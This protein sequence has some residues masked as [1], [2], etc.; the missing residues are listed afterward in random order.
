MHKLT[1][2]VS[3]TLSGDCLDLVEVADH[4][5]ITHSDWTLVRDCADVY[6]L[7]HA[8][9]IEKTLRLNASSALVWQLCTG[10]GS[11]A[12][13]LR[14]AIHATG[15]ERRRVI[16]DVL[17]AL[18]SFRRHEVIRLAES[19][20]GMEVGRCEEATPSTTS[21][22]ELRPPVDKR[23]RLISH[24]RSGTHYLWELMRSNLGAGTQRESSL[25]DIPKSHKDYDE[26]SVSGLGGKRVIYV[27]RDCR[28]VLVA[29][30]CYFRRGGEGRLGGRRILEGS[31]FHDFI[32][33]RIPED[34]NSAELPEFTRE[35][36][37]DPVGYWV[38]HTQWAGRVFTV[39]YED[40]QLDTI[41]SLVR[42][43]REFGM[44][45]DSR[46]FT[47]LSGLVGHYPRRGVVGDW[48]EWFDSSDLDYVESIAGE[49]MLE[50]GYELNSRE[51][52]SRV[53]APDSDINR[54][55]FINLSRR[56]DREQATRD[57]LLRAGVNGFSR[58]DAIDGLEH[59]SV[60]TMLDRV[61]MRLSR[62]FLDN[63]PDFDPFSP[64][65]RAKAGCWLSHYLVIASIR[66]P[67]GWT[68]VL[69]DDIRV[70][71]SWGVLSNRLWHTLAAFPDADVVVV[72]QR[73]GMAVD[74]SRRGADGYLV[75]NRSAEKLRKLLRTDCE[76]IES[77]AL[78]DRLVQL[79][80][81]GRVTI[82]ELSGGEWL[83]CMEVGRG[84]DSDIEN[85]SE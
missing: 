14:E 34:V 28:D 6:Y 80:K 16:Q 42:I 75:R 39:R 78:D 29:N 9:D 23:F 62:K 71:Y 5:V 85:V 27:V 36:F 51:T 45:F 56:P 18:F 11:V 22:S 31:D 59:E 48:R 10:G 77:L 15:A 84:R 57:S 79:R 60:G 26:L 53:P 81:T 12:S 66:D 7:R 20:S 32:R 68:L 58:F 65:F 76:D 21:T 35:Y 2:D 63:R 40:L 61:G 72:S 54:V 69:E 64:R 52:R 38:R 82:A 17:A 41:G 24:R 19:E 49:R 55:V 67:S 83:T 4:R 1:D 8:R 44:D 37:E 30:Y 33:G 47:P 13:V 70:D 46:N 50:L 25:W 3:H 74:G 43:A 73:K